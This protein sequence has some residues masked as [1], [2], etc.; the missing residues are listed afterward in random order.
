MRVPHSW[1]GAALAIVYTVAAT[2][3]TQDEI[4]HPHGGWINLRG[5]GT[6][7]IT[8]PSQILVAPVL[9]FLGVPQVNYANLGFA[10]YAQ[11][12]IH[13]LVSA[14]AVYLL[15]AALHAGGRKAAVFVRR[16]PS[17]E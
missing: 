17:E 8:A 4:R 15:G 7:L 13:I 2:Y 14:T 6:T 3:I 10:A 1:V 11:F 12:L 9:K 16:A 5:F